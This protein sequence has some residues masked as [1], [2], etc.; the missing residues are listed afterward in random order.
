MHLNPHI[1]DKMTNQNIIDV[2][3]VLAERNTAGRG[4][5]ASYSYGGGLRQRLP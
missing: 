3:Q 5:M 1:Y 4:G 2:K